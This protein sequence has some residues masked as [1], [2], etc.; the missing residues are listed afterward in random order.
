M[1]DSRRDSDI[2]EDRTRLAIVD[3]ESGAGL[4]SFVIGSLKED[5]VVLDR[6]SVV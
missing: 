2:S 5:R 3:R 1:E 4:I 6:K